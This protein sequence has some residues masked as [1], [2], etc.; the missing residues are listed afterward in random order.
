MTDKSEEMENNNNDRLREK[1]K[2]IIG[3]AQKAIY[4]R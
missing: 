3:T 4:T 1:K 2:R